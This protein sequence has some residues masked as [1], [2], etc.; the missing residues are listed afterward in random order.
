MTHS[1]ATTATSSFPSSPRR[2][3]AYPLGPGHYCFSVWAPLLPQVELKLLHPI[4][5]CVPLQQNA[6]GYWQVELEGIPEGPLEYLF[7]LHHEQGVVER[8]DPASRW[9]PHGVHGPSRVLP[10]HFD[11][12]DQD[13]QGI[14]LPQWILYELH[15][16]T[17]TPEGTFTAIIPRL[18]DLVDLGVNVIELMPVAQCPGGRNWGYD[19][20][21]PYA[22]QT[23]Y[24]GATGLK[25]LVDACHR[26]GIAVILDVVYNHMGPEGNY[27]REFGPYF[28]DKYHTPWGAALNF[29]DRYCDGVR[30]F[31]L[32][33]AEYWLEE[34][35]LDGLRLDA[36]HA[37]Y[38]FSARPF[39]REL[40][41]R[42]EIVSQRSGWRRYLIAETD[43]NDVKIISPPEQGGYGI[44]AQWCDDFHHCI[45]TLLTGEKEGY[46]EDF[47]QLEQLAKS[48]RESYVF[49]GQYSRYRARRYGNL[50]LSRPGYQFVVCIQ[51]HD[52]IG[53]RMLGERLGQLTS[54]EGLKLAA[55][56]LLL[57]PM[58]PMLFMGEEYGETAPF[59]YFVSHGDPDLVEAVRQG[60]K[61]EFSAFAWKG[62]VPDPQ[63]EETFNRSQL[64]WHLKSEGQHQVLWRWY[65]TLIQLR[66][67]LPALQSFE[68]A[69]VQAYLFS[70][71]GLALQRG[72]GSEQLI[73]LLNF[74]PEQAAIYSGWPPGSWQ[75]LLDSQDPQW[76]GSGS[77]LPLQTAGDP[78]TI[79][80]Y[81]VGVYRLMGSST[82]DSTLIKD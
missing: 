70:E 63:S 66:K 65:Q 81:G 36:V 31:F 43:L 42:V 17:F 20:V 56:A 40:S 29:D 53:N 7:V 55:A 54:F 67:T 49:S 30:E 62:E 13:W 34:F 74:S 47:G 10:P 24:G 60:R 52:Q 18:P 79:P 45:H 46:Y 76:L 28:T 6:E 77:S 9:Q 72:Q 15:V 69:T 73:A 35:H 2:I 68:R 38:D 33:N 78:I 51:N 71:S 12:Q 26:A 25:Q 82:V 50:A 58:L 41:E 16:G 5:Q 48:Y 21:Y 57:A 75:K 39:L 27:L 19:G 32:Q 22:V 1:V 59:Q 3:G 8:P 11:W 14:P 80:A 23:A 37:I 64:N 61:R 4:E 44:D